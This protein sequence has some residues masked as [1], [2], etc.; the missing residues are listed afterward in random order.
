MFFDSVMIK[1]TEEIDLTSEKVKVTTISKKVKVFDISKDK[2]N[3]KKDKKIERDVVD[4][5]FNRLTKNKSGDNRSR[6][7]SRYYNNHSAI[8]CFNCGESGHINKE[9]K[10]QKKKLCLTCCKTDHDSFSCPENICRK[11]NR[12]GHNFRNCDSEVAF[13]FDYIPT[14][15]LSNFSSYK[16]TEGGNFDFENALCV[17]CGEYGHVNC[18]NYIGKQSM[19]KNS[20][21]VDHVDT[22][23]IILNT[24]TLKEEEQQ[25]ELYILPVVIDETGRVTNPE[26][27]APYKRVTIFCLN[28]GKPGHDFDSCHRQRV[29]ETVR[30]FRA[31][32]E[33]CY[34]CNGIGHLRDVC[35]KASYNEDNSYF[36]YQ[37]Q[38]Q[39]YRSNFST[40]SRKYYNTPNQDYKRK[41]PYTENSNKKKS[42]WNDY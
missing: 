37:P 23:N 18:V 38:T 14:D 31:P 19:S 30:N 15:T 39:N 21:E 5:L 17:S 35:P 41:R 28:C 36:D 11:C 4:K 6:M 34:T 26:G 22:S 27:D 32:L 40:P 12:V 13:I 24:E 10:S 9:C 33:T 2:S 7:K 3:K 8:R 20:N 25:Q 16:K 29:E 1:K 42:R